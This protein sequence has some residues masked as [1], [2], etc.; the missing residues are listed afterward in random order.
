M[1]A[2][3]KY[4]YATDMNTTM[5]DQ[6]NVQLYTIGF[7]N[8]PALAAG[9]EWLSA[10]ATAG[11]GQFYSAGDLA[12]LQTVLTNIVNKIQKTSTT[13][14]APSVSVNAFNRTQTLN[15]L[16]V[17]VF[18][19]KLTRHWPGNLKRY[20]IQNS[21][22]VDANNALAVGTNGFFKQSAKSVWSS[23][24]DGY[25]VAKGGASS[26]IPADG[27]RKVYTYIGTGTPTA[28]VTLSSS[29]NTLFD[30]T[31]S[32]LTD[33]ALGLGAPGDPTKSDLI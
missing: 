11:G 29:T 19:P 16:Y 17:S 27:S 9:S 32:L 18:Q 6:Q 22:I 31:N 33:T 28:G 26:Q 14:T 13:F 8:D 4:M 7:G 23:V 20:K 3:A 15:D 30:A 10:A 12:G 5:A 21:Q 24:T 1:A 25:D 2:L